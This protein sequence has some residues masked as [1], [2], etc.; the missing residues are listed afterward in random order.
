M[1]TLEDEW[2]IVIETYKLAVFEIL[3]DCF[4]IAMSAL[5]LHRESTDYDREQIVYPSTI[6]SLQY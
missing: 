5:S 4:C 3:R 2:Y 6:C 1:K